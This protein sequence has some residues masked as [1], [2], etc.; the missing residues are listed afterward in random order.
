[1]LLLG[2]GVVSGRVHGRWPGLRRDQLLGPGDLA[3]T[4]DCRDIPSEL[5]ARRLR[6][7]HL[8][9]IFPG[10]TPTFRGVSR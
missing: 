4:T 7:P 6:S 3:V 8:P 2:G 1:M 9:A 10:Y 5:V